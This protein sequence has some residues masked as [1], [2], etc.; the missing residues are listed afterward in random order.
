MYRRGSTPRSP[1]LRWSASCG[2][3]P[4]AVASRCD[5]HAPLR[6]LL[7][8][9][10]MDYRPTVVMLL[11]ESENISSNYLLNYHPNSQLF[12]PDH[13]VTLNYFSPG[14]HVYNARLLCSVYTIFFV[15]IIR[16][17]KY[18]VSFI[19]RLQQRE[20]TVARAR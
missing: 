2:L 12:S 13:T 16:D 18:Y 19:G 1:A 4:I 9:D 20:A 11:S 10:W 8:L 7:L 5:C 6:L 14:P 15:F 17:K 3:S